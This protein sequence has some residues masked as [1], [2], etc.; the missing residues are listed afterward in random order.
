MHHPLALP[1]LV[2]RPRIYIWMKHTKQ[3]EGNNHSVIQGHQY[4]NV[5]PANTEANTIPNVIRLRQL[6]ARNRSVVQ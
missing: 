2:I 6:G 5:I 3:K 4:S 1:F